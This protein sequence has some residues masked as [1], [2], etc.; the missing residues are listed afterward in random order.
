[1]DVRVKQ[2]LSYKRPL[3]TFSGLGSGFAPRH[4]IRWAAITYN[5]CGDRK[6]A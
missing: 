4:L 2:R 3:V 1:M 5:G 6:S